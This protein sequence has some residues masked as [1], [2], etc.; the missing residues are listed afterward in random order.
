[1]E[2]KSLPNVVRGPGEYG[3]RRGTTGENFDPSRPTS[4]A[5]S[6]VA[7]P[8]WGELGNLQYCWHLA[9]RTYIDQRQC[10]AIRDMAGL[11]CH[12]FGGLAPELGEPW[13]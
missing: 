10:C 4:L 9:C 13:I 11:L 8:S 6:I 2:T 1:M 12:S 7:S 3:W 5:F